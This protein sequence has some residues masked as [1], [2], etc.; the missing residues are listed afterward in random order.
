MKP[1]THQI[2]AIE[3]ILLK[4]KA[5]L[6]NPT[7]SG[8]TLTIV[9]VLEKIKLMPVLIVVPFKMLEKHWIN[10]CSHLD[11]VT[12]IH[13][14]S[15]NK[16]VLMSFN[17]VVVDESHRFKSVTAKRS[18]ILFHICQNAERVIL[19]T[20]TPFETHPTETF[21][22]HQMLG[23]FGRY[24]YK[25]FFGFRM[26]F[27]ESRMVY[28]RGG[29]MI[30]DWMPKIK[31]ETLNEFR[32]MIDKYEVKTK[33]KESSH[34]TVVLDYVKH[35]SSTRRKTPV[36]II[37]L[38]VRLAEKRLEVLKKRF[39][40]DKLKNSI[41]FVKYLKTAEIVRN[42]LGA[43]EL[44]SNSKESYGEV[45]AS[46]MTKDDTPLVLSYDV[47]GAGIDLR[48]DGID[49]VIFLESPSN[50]S[51]EYQALSRIQNFKQDAS[52]TVYKFSDGGILDKSY[53]IKKENYIDKVEKI[54]LVG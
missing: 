22:M 4:K 45:V 7:R 41:I 54:V 39:D 46:W 44:T 29:R 16:V 51:K 3:E 20:A 31:K 50:P 34:K 21:V 38:K 19:S 26:R 18:K 23:E 42:E 32:K 30:T 1:A 43:I 10:A 48:K 53:N 28:G 17:T 37:D 47:G 15:L 35:N 33:L 2:T 9:K 25:R 8:K 12:V 13:S 6:T 40:Q 24:E 49:T 52:F 14:A 27:V 11:N 36:E 5:I